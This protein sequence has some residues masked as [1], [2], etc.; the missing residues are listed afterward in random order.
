MKLNEL[1]KN[2]NLELKS[3]S[4][5]LDVEV[6]N[7]YAGDIL[8]DVMSHAQE[9]SVWITL[10]THRN[11]VSVAML[12]SLAGIILIGGRSP[13]DETLKKANEEN[14]P[15]LSTNLTTFEIVGKL[16]ELGIRG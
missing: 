5:A 13:D 14:I 8:S 1:I 12:K 3:T 4:T 10:Q 6:T 15:I 2:L 7:A 9:G 16:Y 11:T